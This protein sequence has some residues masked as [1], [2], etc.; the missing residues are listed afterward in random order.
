MILTDKFVYLHMGKT[1]GTFVRNAVEE[2]YSDLFVK[3]LKKY[4]LFFLSDIYYYKL[5]RSPIR[6]LKFGEVWE[7]GSQHNFISHIPPA[8]RGKPVLSCVRNPYDYYVSEYTFG[9]WKESPMLEI[10]ELKQRYEHFPDL[11][12]REYLR[13]LYDAF[14][15]EKEILGYR[16]G[17]GVYTCKFIEMYYENYR[18][19]LRREEITLPEPGVEFI[20]QPNLNRELREEL[21]SLGY[22]KE[23]TAHIP[24]LGRINVS[25]DSRRYRDYYDEELADLVYRNEKP[26]FDL[27]GYEK[28]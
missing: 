16:S 12:F 21:R 7:K 3:L 14:E 22:G 5:Y 27:F 20:R 1:G 2:M 10:E 11:S 17:Y 4:N 25:R 28:L 9:W 26:L 19:M 8:F 15:V 18:K 23:R 6:R 13:Y 24:S